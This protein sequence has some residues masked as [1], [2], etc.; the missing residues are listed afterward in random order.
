MSVSIDE[1]YLAVFTE[2]ITEA[3]SDDTFAVTYST[4][5]KVYGSE[6]RVVYAEA[7]VG[8]FEAPTQLSLTEPADA[9]LVAPP[10]AEVF[11][12]S[13]GGAHREMG[14]LAHNTTS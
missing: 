4:M 12:L 1:Q 7:I 8:D 5:G 11:V 2:E 14:C 6:V 3:L 10:R 13:D 9:V